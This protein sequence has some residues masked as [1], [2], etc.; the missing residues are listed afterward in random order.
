[1]G[2]GYHSHSPEEFRKFLEENRKQ[3]SGGKFSRVRLIFILNLVL[4]VLVIG[5]VARTTLPG[6]FTIQSSSPKLKI[7]SIT[8]Y[9]K[10]SR[11]GKEGFPTFFLFMKNEDD[12]KE[13]RFPDTS[14]NFK[15]LLNSKDGI[16]CVNTIWNVPQKTLYPGKIEFARFRLSDD[17]IDSLPPDCKTKSFENFLERIFRKVHSQSGLKLVLI[18]SHKEGQKFLSIENP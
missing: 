1:M 2:G 14:W 7:G 8:L 16:N 3:S 13:T 5:M 17:A 10:S 18:I 15:I 12:S 4:V 9:V 11:E 6:A